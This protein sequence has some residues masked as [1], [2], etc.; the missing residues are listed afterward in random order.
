MFFLCV[1][2]LIKGITLKIC[3]LHFVLINSI[4]LNFSCVWVHFPGQSTDVKQSL[5]QATGAGVAVDEVITLSAILARI[6][7][8]LIDIKGTC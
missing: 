4:L 1:C 6:T 7:L 8:T 3:I 5:T 2:G